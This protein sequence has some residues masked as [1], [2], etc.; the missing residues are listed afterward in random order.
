MSNYIWNAESFNSNFLVQ[1]RDVSVPH[2]DDEGSYPASVGF[3]V[4]CLPNNRVMYFEDHVTDSNFVSG[5]THSQIVTYSWGNLKA[6]ISNWAGNALNMPSLV[7]SS[8][9]PSVGSNGE[10]SSN[11]S[12]NLGTYNSNYTTTIARFEVYPPLHPEVWC[13]GFT[14]TNNSNNLSRYFDTQ[15][16]VTTFAVNEQED[17]LMNVA[18]SQLKE[19]IGDW[20]STTI[21]YSAMINSQFTPNII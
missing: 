8:F 2:I 10:F 15:Y 20:A 13:I 11:V 17:A 4:I 12:I 18:W 16:S 14:C 19:T 21:H 5:A 6:S 7:G 9:V 3:N 1:I